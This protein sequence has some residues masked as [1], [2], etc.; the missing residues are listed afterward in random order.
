M[1]E[2]DFGEIGLAQ[3]SEPTAG[4][5]V[6]ERQIEIVLMRLRRRRRTKNYLY[7]EKFAVG[8]IA[9]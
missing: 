9:E 2:K 6:R 7:S 5:K 1:A 3:K 4:E 8:G